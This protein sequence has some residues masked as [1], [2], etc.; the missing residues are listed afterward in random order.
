MPPLV[1]PVGSLDSCFQVKGKEGSST[2]VGEGLGQPAGLR[3]HWR[4]GGISK[5]PRGLS[6]GSLFSS[7][8]P[9]VGCRQVGSK[10]LWPLSSS[11]AAGH[12]SELVCTWK[13]DRGLAPSVSSQPTFACARADCLTHG[14][15]TDLRP[16]QDP[17]MPRPHLGPVDPGVPHCPHVT[18]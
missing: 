7:V 18:R 3:T 8:A 6:A 11:P 1:S 5:A 2:W 10:L 15:R 14:A 9:Q 4:A 17:G 12:R 16:L 13:G